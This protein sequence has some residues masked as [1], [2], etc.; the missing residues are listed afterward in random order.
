MLIKM[1]PNARIQGAKKDGLFG[2]LFGV[3]IGLFWGL[4]GPG[5]AQFSLA[6]PGAEFAAH[7]LAFGTAIRL[8]IADDAIAF[9]N[10]EE[11]PDLHFLE[12]T[13]MS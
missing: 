8:Q 11:V 1:A 6:H 3:E 5:Y 12:R 7:P 4:F 10:V 2:R 13:D 9:G